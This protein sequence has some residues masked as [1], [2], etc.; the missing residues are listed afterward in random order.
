MDSAQ[1]R[2]ALPVNLDSGQYLGYD[3]CKAT[4]LDRRIRGGGEGIA[5]HWVTLPDGEVRCRLDCCD[6][7]RKVAIDGGG[8]V[9]GD[10]CHFSRL[11]EWIQ[12]CKTFV[13]RGLPHAT[14][15]MN[16]LLSSIW[17]NSSPV[18][19]GPTLT[20][21]GFFSPLKNST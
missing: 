7:L 13:E 15:R 2:A 8:T 16:V 18:I 4:G 3:G 9:T 1:R 20:P 5:M 10:Q 11:I 12:N 14:Q 19:V 21:T 17:T 6:V